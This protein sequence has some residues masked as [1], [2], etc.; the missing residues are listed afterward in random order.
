ML[1]ISRSFVVSAIFVRAFFSIYA[2]T[3]SPTAVEDLASQTAM[4][5]A[6]S[7]ARRIL[8]VTLPSCS[9]AVQ[10]CTE[11]DTRLRA[12]LE[13]TIPSV[14]FVTQ[15]DAVGAD[16]RVN[17]GLVLGGGIE[18]QSQIVAATPEKTLKNFTVCV[19]THPACLYCT[20][21]IIY[22][23]ETGSRKA[24]DALVSLLATI[25]PEGRAANVTVVKGLDK[26]LDQQA[27][28]AVQGWRFKPAMRDGRPIATRLPV[29]MP[30]RIYQIRR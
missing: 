17:E 27:V 11:F 8:T 9:L 10:V 16:V 7:S 1:G 25:T 15:D 3:P 22:A 23:P 30:V 4:A 12:K 26:E 21:Q 13:Q 14:Q 29:T 28:Q 5:A 19:A 2:C 6:Q 20:P 18:L 24:G